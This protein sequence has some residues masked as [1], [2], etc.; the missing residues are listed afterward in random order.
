MNSDLNFYANFG[1]L[2]AEFDNFLSYTHVNA[3]LISI[4]PVPY[5]LAG[6]DVAHAPRH[7]A[8]IGVNYYITENWILNTEVESKGDF[9]FSDRHNVK[10]DGFE[11]Y[12]LRLTYIQNDWRVNLFAH[13]LM[14]EDIQT[15]GFGS[16]GNDP[17][18][19]YATEAYYQFAAPRVIGISASM[20]FN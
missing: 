18:K 3:D 12:N 10:S 6:R 4:P 16:F 13:N 14:N 19:F 1:L 8:T 9:Y 2:Q 17:R 7:Q 15:R 11:L 5:N 20:E